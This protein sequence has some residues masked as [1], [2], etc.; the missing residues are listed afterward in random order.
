[1]AYTGML[2][3]KGLPFSGLGYIKKVG[4]LLA[5]S[6]VVLQTRHVEGIPFIKKRY[7]KGVHNW[8]TVG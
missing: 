1:M 7:T 4:I 5:K 8:Y 2:Y 3:P 6:D